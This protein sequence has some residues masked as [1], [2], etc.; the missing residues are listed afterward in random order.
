M[1]IDLLNSEFSIGFTGDHTE[2]N[3]A[4]VL[5]AS[6][7]SGSYSSDG[8]I[9]CTSICAPRALRHGFRTYGPGDTVGCG[10]DWTKNIYFF[11]HNGR[12]GGMI[13]L[14]AHIVLC[15]NS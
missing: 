10:I 9:W 3:H 7:F 2:K 13:Q 6:I 14:V 4:L 5:G 1:L 15:V 12:K 11:T 8:D